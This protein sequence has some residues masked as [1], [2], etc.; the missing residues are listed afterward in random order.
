M[1]GTPFHVLLFVLAAG[2]GVVALRQQNGAF[3]GMSLAIACVLLTTWIRYGGVM[4]AGRHYRAGR[5]DAAWSELRRVPLRGR[6]LAAGHRPYFH[7]L[8]AAVLLDRGE[9]AA[10]LREGEAVLAMPKTNAANHATAHGAMSKA[11][12]MLGDHAAAAEHVRLARTM[13]HKP[14]LDRL[15][16]AVAEGLE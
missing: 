10:V 2:V 12:L 11:L 15:L 3:A 8:R 6:L 5:R 9:W 4:A 13:P 7:L 14:G 1:I 16:A